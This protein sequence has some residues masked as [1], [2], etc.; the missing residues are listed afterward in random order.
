MKV[1]WSKCARYWAKVSRLRE[2]WWEQ[3]LPW[4]FSV[5]EKDDREEVLDKEISAGNNKGFQIVAW[6]K[7]AMFDWDVLSV[8][9]DGEDG[10]LS[11]NRTM[12]CKLNKVFEGPVLQGRLRSL[13]KQGMGLRVYRTPGGIRAFITSYT[14]GLQEWVEMAH[15]LHVDMSYVAFCVARFTTPGKLGG[16]AC[17]TTPKPGREGDYVARLIAQYG[18]IDESLRPYLAHHDALIARFH[19]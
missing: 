9:E 2:K 11:D 7:L 4:Y 17:R 13:I 14:P 10:W 3:K 6:S 1:E 19:G 12:V 8:L 16:W 18:H 15:W 5:V